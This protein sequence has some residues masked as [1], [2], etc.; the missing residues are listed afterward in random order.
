MASTMSTTKATLRASSARRTARW[1]VSPLMCIMWD[2][3]AASAADSRTSARR[4]RRVYVPGDCY[5]ET[6]WAR[7]AE[8]ARF[9]QTGVYKKV[10]YRGAME[11]VGKKPAGAKRVDLLKAS[12]THTSR[13]VGKEL[14]NGGDLDTFAAPPPLGGVK[15]SQT[16]A[17]AG[18]DTRNVRGRGQTRKS[19]HVLMRIDIHRAYF[20][21][22]I[23]QNIF[24]QL[25]P[26]DIGPVA[27]GQCWKYVKSIDGRG[28]R[29]SR[30]MN[31]I[32]CEAGACCACVF[33]RGG[34]R[35]AVLVHGDGFLVTARRDIAEESKTVLAQRWQIESVIVGPGGDDGKDMLILN[36]KAVR[37]TGGVEYYIDSMHAQGFAEEWLDKDARPAKRRGSE[38][39]P[40]TGLTDASM[41][42]GGERQAGRRGTRCRSPARPL[43]PQ[44]G[45]RREHEKPRDREAQG[46]SRS[47]ALLG[48]GHVI[49]YAVKGIV[50]RMAEPKH[51]DLEGDHPD[52]VVHDVSRI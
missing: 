17:A 5:H 36:C 28:A 10:P 41:G 9:K 25:P 50:M 4:Q 27:P 32:G 24:L 13:L 15:V 51:K 29:P 14:D 48:V 46:G 22:H 23:D 47:V 20:N 52:R 31:W 37:T 19:D 49:A 30:A 35:A 45:T 33:Q 6:G 1:Y 3:I 12:G 26:E 7:R 42:G 16:M 11:V 8:F 34:G 43:R 21:M 39:P 38:P 18:E 40:S 44:R 2:R